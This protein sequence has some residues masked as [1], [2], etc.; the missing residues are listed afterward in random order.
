MS[1]FK[2]D[3][4]FE[5]ITDIKTE[6]LLEHKIKIVLIDA[7]NTLSLHGSKKPASGVPEWLE[8]I[9]K[10]GFVPVIISNNSENRIRPF[11]EKLGLPF[12][13]KSAKPLPKGFKKATE[14]FGFKP[15]ETAVIGDQIFTDV[16]GGKLFGAKVFLTEPLGPETDFFI[17]IKREFEKFIR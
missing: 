12:V 8:E 11:A 17:K 13:F 14:K 2:P 7:D 4:R 3:F 6:F 15:E 5:K 9:K 10:E 1:I 16:L